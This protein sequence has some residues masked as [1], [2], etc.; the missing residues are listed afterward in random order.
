MPEIQLKM[1]CNNRLQAPSVPNTNKK[2]GHKTLGENQ[3][4][5]EKREKV[6]YK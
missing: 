6:I 5:I 2:N 4:M 3:C 1:F